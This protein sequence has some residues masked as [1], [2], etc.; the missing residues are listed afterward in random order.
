MSNLNKAMEEISALNTAG[1]KGTTKVQGGKIYT[2]VSSRV[3]VFRKHYGLDYG[4]DTQI[5]AFEG[6]VLCKAYIMVGADV[7]GSGHA[8]STNIAKDKSIEKLET[9]AIGR[10][11]AS[12]GLA[13]GEYASDVELDSWEERYEK[14]EFKFKK[15]DLDVF[16]AAVEKEMSVQEFLNLKDQYRAQ[17]DE[18]APHHKSEVIKTIK[19]REIEITNQNLDSNF[20]QKT[21]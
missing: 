14:R 16:R 11:M 2:N 5:S 17:L 21:A 6:G 15:T 10:A 13:G 7:V 18:M 20:K 12:I 8:Y 19:D 4:L 9:T 1:A 3:E